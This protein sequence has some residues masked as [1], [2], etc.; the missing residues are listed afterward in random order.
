MVLRTSAE[1]PWIFQSP[2]EMQAWGRRL[3]PRLKPGDVIALVGPLGAGKTTLAQSIVGRL[4]YQR[5]AVSPTFALVNEY[6]TRRG[7]VYHMDMYR[8][9][10]REREDFPV[11][12]Y[13]NGICLI[14]W[15]DRIRDRWPAD[16]L[17]VRL[18]IRGLNRR[19]LSLPAVPRTWAMRLPARASRV[20]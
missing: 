15:A 16:A 4:G 19:E 14:E 5:G 13:W 20:P 11:E 10:E 17:E 8:L 1:G 2:E 6:R 3:A 18:R 9:S 7:N 12:E